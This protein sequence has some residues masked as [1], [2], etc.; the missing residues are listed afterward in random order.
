MRYIMKISEKNFGAIFNIFII[1]IAATVVFRK[2][3][4]W[5][6][7]AFIVFNLVFFKKIR[8]N[9]QALLLS[10]I[11]ASPFLLEI[12]L[13][14]NNDSV[15]DG[16][17]SV[18]KTVSLLLLPLVI[19]GN[20]KYI[21]FRKILFYYSRLVTLL[22]V[23]MFG[24]FLVLYPE[25]AAKYLQGIHLWEMG[26][27]FSKTFGIHAPALNMH[28]AFVAIVSF[29]FVFQ[30]FRHNEKKIYRAYSLIFLA[31]SIF[32]VLFVNTRMALLNMFAGFL[33]IIIYE[34]IKIKNY[35]KFIAT[36]SLLL[37]VITGVMY[38]F[39]QNNPYMKEKYGKVTF[40]HM[41][42]IGKLDEVPNPESEVFNSLV[43]RVSIWKSAWEL[44]VDNLPL[45]VGS[46][47]GKKDLIA[48]YKQTGQN[49]L[50]KYEFPV[51][52]QFLDFLLRF[53]I[54]GVV[55]ILL[56]IFSIGY[57]GI[58]AKHAVMVSF[59]VL[60][61]TS[62]LTDD[63][64]IRFDGIVFSGLWFTLFCAYRLQQKA[65]YGTTQSV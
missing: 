41:D 53:G 18:E 22:M 11:I 58:K 51:H 5:I 40:A 13:F 14:F 15:S 48:Y 29:Y 38:V 10:G 50:A 52:N 27:F 6:L 49:F 26:Y 31:L 21:T 7:I 62:N 54:P 25:N 57:I 17:K 2:P 37:I 20:Y 64:L 46:A 1:I 59:F 42:K 4:T 12:L 45:G 3:C 28:L 23:F 32:F 35:K 39:I 43:T 33:I 36:V 34:F 63:F 44:S 55:V 24:R 8:L 65:I 61:F 9:K 60:F 47:D 56:Y 30:H 16:L 19:L